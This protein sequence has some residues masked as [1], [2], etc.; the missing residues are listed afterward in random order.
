MYP[1]PWKVHKS[2]GHQTLITPLSQAY[3]ILRRRNPATAWWSCVRRWLRNWPAS[4]HSRPVKPR[5]LP[6]NGPAV[7]PALLLNAG[8]EAPLRRVARTGLYDTARY[9]GPSEAR[10]AVLN[11]FSACGWSLQDVENELAGQFPGLAALYGTA[12]RQARLLPLRVGQSPSLHRPARTMQKPLPR[13]RGKKSALINNT[14]PTLTTGGAGKLSSAAV[15]Q[16][17]NDLENILYAVLDHRLQATRPQGLSLRL[18]IRGLLGYM[19][20][21]R[22][23][24]SRRRLPNSC[25]GDGKTPRHHCQAAARS[26]YRLLMGSSPKSWTP[27]K[28]PPTST[29]SD[30]PSSTNNL[31]GN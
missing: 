3:D 2:G 16:L 27:A 31:P 17:V 6:L 15:Q 22:N 11:H 25:R 1:C 20:A 7:L 9:K 12:Q 23:R 13:K 30:S 4:A 18:L 26:W 19:R 8:S 29:S 10:M 14:S 5:L 28:K 24:H 21:K